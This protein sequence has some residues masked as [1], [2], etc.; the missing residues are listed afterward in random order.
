M[1]SP[2]GT[3]KNI[4]PLSKLQQ[5]WTISTQNL[6]IFWYHT[7]EKAKVL[8]MSTRKSKFPLSDADM[9]HRFSIA[10]V[11]SRLTGPKMLSNWNWQLW[12]FPAQ[13]QNEI[14]IDSPRKFEKLG[15]VNTWIYHYCRLSKSFGVSTSMES[16][17]EKRPNLANVWTSISMQY[18][19]DFQHIFGN[20]C[21]SIAFIFY[22]TVARTF[23]WWRI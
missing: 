4:F 14:M 11:W 23:T 3:E 15:V 1:A 12:R 2:A 10:C 22:E 13:A 17:E 9:L 8:E 6:K 21:L 5:N 18:F 20:R 7:Y 16:F 19:K